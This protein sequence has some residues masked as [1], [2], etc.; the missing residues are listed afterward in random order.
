[1]EAKLADLQK[2]Y[3]GQHKSFTDGI[4]QIVEEEKKTLQKERAT[5]ETDK[6]EW[7]KLKGKPEA[8]PQLLNERIKL[9]IGGTVFAS[10]LATLISQPGSY[11]E[12]MFSGRWKAKKSADG[13]YFIDRDPSAF[14][15]ILNFLRT[16][17]LKFDKLSAT[18]RAALL[19]DAEFYQLY[20]LI[21]LLKVA[22]KSDPKANLLDSL[23]F[24]SGPNHTVSVDG[25]LITNTGKESTWGTTVLGPVVNSDKTRKVEF[26]LAIETTKY[27]QYSNIMFGLAKKDVDQNA[28]CNYVKNGWYLYTNGWTLYSGNG[29]SCKAYKPDWSKWGGSGTSVKVVYDNAKRELSYVVN[30]TNGGVAFT[31]LPADEPLH[32]VV[33]FNNTGDTVR[34]K[35]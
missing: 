6:A 23:K 16:G 13:T 17:G 4:T 31:D 3:L 2:S 20:D 28:S 1:M 27:K 12:A 8:K 24:A 22:E 10:T 33:L 14:R 5:Y 11:F 34:L 15:H 26:N 35:N 18:E 30:D 32:L 21:D 7:E 19:E 25:K 29:D 9:D